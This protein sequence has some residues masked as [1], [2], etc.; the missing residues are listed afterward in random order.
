MPPTANRKSVQIS[1]EYQPA[2]V[3]ARSSELP[4]MA[5]ALAA[6]ASPDGSTLFSAKPAA[7]SSATNAIVA[8]ST[9]PGP[10]I[11]TASPAVKVSVPNNMVAAAN[12]AIS[13]PKT[14]VNCN[15]RR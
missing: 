1:V 4:G 14:S 13:E 12:E 15:G 9:T 5:D 2:A 3:K 11:A 10:S 8:C 6:N 7:P